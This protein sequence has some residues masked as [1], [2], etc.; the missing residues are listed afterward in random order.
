MSIYLENNNTA[1]IILD[2]QKARY[3]IFIM[4]LLICINV[5]SL[6]IVSTSCE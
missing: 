5:R 1:Y 4:E 3:L 2:N 6:F